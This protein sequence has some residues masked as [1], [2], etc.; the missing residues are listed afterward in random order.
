MRLQPLLAEHAPMVGG[1]DSGAVESSVPIAQQ[2][3]LHLEDRGFVPFHPALS[4]RFGHKAAIFVGMALYWTRHSLRNHPQ[5]G[6]WF[7]MS[8]AQ[9]QTSI[10]LTR[11][12]QATVRTELMEAGV[13]EEQLIGRPSVLNYR[14][15]VKALTA[16]LGGTKHGPSKPSLEAVA[17]WMRSCR[18]YYKPLADIASNIAAGL[19][20]SYLL[21]CHR[22]QLR[23]GQLDNGCISASQL[24][25]SE[26]LAL[27]TK[28]QRNARD[29]LKKSGLI[30]EC[31]AGGSLVRLNF[32]A[33]LLC[34]RGQAIKP[35]K[36]SAR[37]A[38]LSVGAAT[39]RA[40]VTESQVSSNALPERPA[41]SVPGLD[42]SGLGIGLQQLTLT[43][44]G[45][46]ATHPPAP[47]RSR[48]LLLHF[49]DD[50][51]PAPVGNRQVVK[52]THLSQ[53]PFETAIKRNGDSD[54]RNLP[55]PLERVQAPRQKNAVSCIL[56]PSES[57]VSCNEPAQ[58]C[59][60]NLPFPA[61]YIQDD[62]SIT[63]TTSEVAQELEGSSSGLEF[64]PE[65]GEV[66][67]QA[68]KAQL[69]YPIALSA[70]QRG[71]VESV[72]HG[73]ALPDKQELLDELHGQM[74]RGKEIRSPAGWLHGIVT[75]KA[76]G[77]PVALVY[78]AEVAQARMDTMTR[79]KFDELGE[80]LGLPAEP[81][82][83]FMQNIEMNEVFS[84]LTPGVVYVIRSTGS[85]VQID[86]STNVL[87]V[88]RS[89]QQAWFVMMNAGP[90][91]RAMRTNDLFPAEE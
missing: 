12:E 71:A 80:R 8:I 85:L 57:A 29:R 65:E 18:V 33:I 67:L 20:L 59:K 61:T 16:A 56:G 73:L 70:S 37:S 21:Q 55:H 35:L 46:T 2:I 86:V 30:Q 36:K 62:I 23:A 49:L 51:F 40:K 84:K 58:S 75:K 47:K 63:T 87:R 24:D 7:H 88:K 50:S 38:D 72:I 1:D 76:Q 77:Q 60:L 39:A 79:E 31:G 28:V 11:T 82:Q 74:A 32:E 3:I 41:A 4:E 89:N 5:R 9:W 91:V 48:D 53:K 64:A 27:G 81:N 14:I 68:E 43:L 66:S 42:L 19:Y 54:L 22:D 6:G 69:V 45:V 34:L 17:S 25:I 78:A 13:L 90:L 26:S 15:N 83:R 10:G 44:E 52:L